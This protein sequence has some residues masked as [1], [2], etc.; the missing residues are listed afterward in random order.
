MG[1]DEKTK[2]EVETLINGETIEKALNAGI[3]YNELD[4]ETENIWS[5]LLFTGYLTYVKERREAGA[6]T[7]YYSLKIPNKE[8][9][10]I[11]ENIIRA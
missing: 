7:S 4:E 10:F 3:T 5:M 1:A 2:N 8:L 9:L 11:Y 6:V